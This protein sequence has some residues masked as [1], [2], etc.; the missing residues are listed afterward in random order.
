MKYLN[1]IYA[2]TILFLVLLLGCQKNENGNPYE[3]IVPVKYYLSEEDKSLLDYF[4]DNK[5][6]TFSD[7]ENNDLVFSTDSLYNITEKE[8]SNLRNGEEL[9]MQYS[10]ITEYFPNYS[11]VITLEAVDTS[12]VSLQIMFATGTY[13]N[14][15]YNDYVLSKFIIDPK[16][17][18]S[19][20]TT[21][22][23]RHILKFNYYDS[24]TFRSEQFYKVYHITKQIINTSIKQTMDC[25]YTNE[26]G[27]VAFENL[28]NKFWIRKTQ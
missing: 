14:D 13:W 7:Q 25:Y 10:C 11:F 26:L 5:T 2:L 16:S 3:K 12:K 15:R 28:D 1:W 6:I 9:I 23:N 22:P 18:T 19:V 24:L 8:E 4:N 17:V 20:D 21:F 27:V